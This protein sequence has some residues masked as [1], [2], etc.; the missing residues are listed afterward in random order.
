MRLIIVCLFCCI[1]ISCDFIGSFNRHTSNILQC[2]FMIPSGFKLDKEESVSGTPTVYLLKNDKTMIITIHRHIGDKPVTDENLNIVAA[3]FILPDLGIT[4]PYDI[5][6]VVK[7]YGNR[8]VSGRKAAWFDYP[9]EA[10]G[11]LKYQ[12]FVAGEE[13]F[14][15]QVSFTIVPQENFNA[16]KDD[17]LQKT[18]TSFLD[19]FKIM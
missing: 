4:D 14:L 7:L 12:V 2:S 16:S 18:I 13:N 15:Y 10:H 6:K 5:G 9:D 8:Q 3:S 17:E 1:L 19:G 11:Y